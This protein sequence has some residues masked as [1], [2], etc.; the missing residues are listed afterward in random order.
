MANYSEDGGRTWTD[1][2]PLRLQ[3]GENLLGGMSPQLVRLPSG[4]L[5][6]ASRA[7]QTAG[8]D[9]GYLNKFMEYTFHISTN[10]GVN[11]SPGV[12]INPNNVY[13][14]G[15][16]SGVDGL[17][18]LSDGRL[19]LPFARPFGPTPRQEKGSNE[20]LFGERMSTGW[21]SKVMFSYAYY[22]DDEG[23][24]WQ[25]SRNEVHASLDN[26]MSGGFGMDEPAIAELVDDR[27]IL[28]ALTPLGRMFRSYSADRGET[29][30]QAEPTDL[31]VRGGGCLN[32]KR[33]PGTDD[34]LII[35]CQLSRFECMQGLY[36][37]RVTC[38][39]SKDGGLSWQHHRNLVSLDDTTRID[40]GPLVQWLSG[41]VR[42]PLDRKR[43]HRA[44]GPLRND[45]TYCTFQNGTAIIVTSQGVLGEKAVIEKT[46][47]MDWDAL[48][49]KFGFEPNPRKPN[50]VL[51]NNR[52][53]VVPVEWLYA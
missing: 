28:I 8:K 39:I 33:I 17:V 24:N 7:K 10:D 31:A 49:K 12:S 6:M 29:W 13:T 46:Y 44:P 51:G 21:A 35:W 52:I 37:H 1:P 11:W 23:R 53:H 36:R 40:P 15:E 19:V 25:R 34:L 32:L 45:H 26:G 48:T 43:Y 14:H 16:Y 27:L 41:T 38:A 3:D 20:K 47:G 9:S 22:S 30:L 4:N 42:Q 5:G 18:C 50:S 2:V